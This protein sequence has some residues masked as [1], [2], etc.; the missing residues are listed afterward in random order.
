M[1]KLSSSRGRR[2]ISKTEK[3]RIVEESYASDMGTAE[4]ARTNHVGLSSLIRWRKQYSEGGKMSVKSDD[5]VISKREYQ[6]LKKE[7]RNIERLLG[8]KTAENEVLKEAVTIAREK[9]LI[10][11]SAWQNVKSLVTD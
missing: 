9:K 1:L 5:A 10:S 8:R 2:Y 7:Y 6:K 11:E 4:V 3:V